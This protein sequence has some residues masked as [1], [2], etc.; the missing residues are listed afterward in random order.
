MTSRVDYEGKWIPALKVLSMVL[1]LI[2]ITPW[3]ESW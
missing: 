3:H 2:T 1:L